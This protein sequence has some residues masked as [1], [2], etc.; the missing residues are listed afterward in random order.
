MALNAL[1][2]VATEA[3]RSDMGWSTF[4]ERHVKATMRYEV[5]LERM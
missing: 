3:L 5:R 4:K 1:R 2:Y